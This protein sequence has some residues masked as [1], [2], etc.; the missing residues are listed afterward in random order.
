MFVIF[1]WNTTKEKYTHFH[2]L[3]RT[4]GFLKIVFTPT[5]G[6]KHFYETSKLQWLEGAWLAA[7]HGQWLRGEGWP[8]VGGLRRWLKASS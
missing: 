7:G 5:N 3:K 1:N 8:A 4:V 6:L 2:K